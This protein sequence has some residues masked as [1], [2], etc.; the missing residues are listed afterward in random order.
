MNKYSKPIV[1]GSNIG[2]F[3][4][5]ITNSHFGLLLASNHLYLV[6]ISGFIFKISAVDGK[7]ISN[8]KISSEL[9]RAPIIVNNRMF[10][11]NRSSELI[12]LN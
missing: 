4:T 7:Y 3:S 2:I 5:P 9:S 10:I 6:S 1:E 12:I 8:K 11:L